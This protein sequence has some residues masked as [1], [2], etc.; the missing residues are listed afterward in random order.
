MLPAVAA[1]AAVGSLVYVG[2]HHLTHKEKD[3]V[4]APSDPKL[5]TTRT[6]VHFATN[7][8]NILPDSAP[9]LNALV[10]KLHTQLPNVRV[11]VQGHTDDTG[12][13]ALNMALSQ[14]RAQSVVNYMVS[15][16]IVPGRLTAKGY[17]MTKPLVPNDSDAHRA[18]NR[19]VEF[20]Q[21]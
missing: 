16:G 13:A 8:A 21:A 15:H 17:G 4:A 12:T 1:V 20:V 18:I 6:L 3:G 9:V 2:W 5:E 11:E 19:R 7:Q 10:E 14:A